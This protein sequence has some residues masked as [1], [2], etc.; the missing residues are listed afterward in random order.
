MAN[1]A[2]LWPSC[3]IFLSFS[4]L[5]GQ[6]E[7]NKLHVTLRISHVHRGKDRKPAW[8]R[9]PRCVFFSSQVATLVACFSIGVTWK[10]R[11]CGGSCMI[12][13]HLLQ[14]KAAW[15]E[16]LEVH[17][18]VFEVHHSPTFVIRCICGGGWIIVGFASPFLDH[19]AG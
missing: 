18:R 19:F 10:Q 4:I 5:C 1:L 16:V 17:Q 3:Q 6:T 8:K 11:R 14:S 2:H 15:V 9:V 13:C 7:K 12:R